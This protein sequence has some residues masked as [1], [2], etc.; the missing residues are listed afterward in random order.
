MEGS[1][2]MNNDRYILMNKNRPLVEVEVSESGFII[3]TYKI[4]DESALPVGV[5]VPNTSLVNKLNEWWHSRIIPASR[6]GLKFILHLY[7][8]ES[9]SILSKRSLGLSLSDQYWI[10]PIDSDLTWDAVNFFTNEFSAELGEAFFSAPGIPPNFPRK[11][12]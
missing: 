9:A 8:I 10:K 7:D 6:D 2:K 3:A 12:E 11:G 1:G 5:Y 4:Y